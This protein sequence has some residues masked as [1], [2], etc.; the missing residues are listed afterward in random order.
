MSGHPCSRGCKGRCHCDVTD[1]LDRL[2]AAQPGWPKVTPGPR[3]ML[4]VVP[5]DLPFIWEPIYGW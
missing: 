5:V 3:D 1:L 4:P 2:L